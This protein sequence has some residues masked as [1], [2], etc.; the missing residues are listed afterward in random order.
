MV[1]NSLAIGRV[2]FLE[3]F[4]DLGIKYEPPHYRYLE[5][6]SLEGLKWFVEKVISPETQ[7]Y[8]P[9]VV[10][11]SINDHNTKE[12]DF[13]ALSLVDSD[14]L[15]IWSRIE[16]HEKWQYYQTTEYDHLSTAAGKPHIIAVLCGGN[17]IKAISRGGISF[18]YDLVAEEALE[19]RSSNKYE[20]CDIVLPL[21]TIKNEAKRYLTMNS[22]V[23]CDL[24]TYVYL[25]KQKFLSSKESQGQDIKQCVCAN[26][27][28]PLSPRCV[29][30]YE[31]ADSFFAV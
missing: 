24:Q 13:Y 10:N 21:I 12:Y 6:N 8:F 2:P 31:R 20:F 11:N 26:E 16:L 25:R 9:A 3:F 14:K 1:F 17:T 22:I 30:A 28:H 4:V 5:G 19:S 15:N 29:R 7:S 27:S 23:H 18:L